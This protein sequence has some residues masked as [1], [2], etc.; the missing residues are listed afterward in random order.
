MGSF[1]AWLKELIH[2]FK[3]WLWPQPV[4]TP[5]PQP[6]PE[7]EP[8]ATTAPPP[9]PQVAPVFPHR[10]GKWVKPK[11]QRPPKSP[12]AEGVLRQPRTPSKPKPAPTSLADDPEQYGQYYFRDAIL[13]QLDVY[14]IYLKRMKRN[15][16]DAYNMHRKL[17]IHIMPQSAIRNFDKWRRDNEEAELSAWWKVNRP[18]F[19]AV[20]YG[21][22]ADSLEEEQYQIV[23]VSP[24]MM[25]RIRKT[26]K[27]KWDDGKHY[28]KMV[29][30]TGGKEFTLPDGKTH[31]PAIIWV[32]KFLYFTKWSKVP[33]D[34]Q[35]VVNGDVYSMT[36]YWDRTTGMSNTY[37][38]RHK[39]GAP[40]NYAICVDRDTG[41][42]R[43][44]KTFICESI[45]I[46]SKKMAGGSFKIPHKHW[47]YPTEYVSGASGRLDM[48]PEEYLCRVFMEAAL[49]YE[50]ASLGSMVRIT[51]SKDSGKLNAVF[52]VDIK[53]MA[54]FFKD[55]DVVLN[56]KGSTARIFHIVRPH[57]RK[58]GASVPMHFRGLKSFNWANYKID[59]TVPGR[60]HLHLSSWD[61]GSVNLT[62]D[63]F[64]K[65]KKKKMLDGG[66]VADRLKQYMKDGLG[67]WQK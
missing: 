5:D 48:P 31:K 57:T 3:L 54:Y 33:A 38:K 29:T 58:S 67:A 56:A 1:T 60:D 41:K 32:P 52:G 4:T 40:Q 43:L 12:A 10:P 23:D 15:D 49:M 64:K 45:T 11:G 18:G 27:A 16:I 59:I 66:Q 21:I 2:K 53:R 19:G 14:F 61:V 37:H 30:I 44:L 9:A 47:G 55:R 34:V 42:V 22:D 62:P 39:G 35:K 46:A 17:G 13:D 6:M 50:N 51:A 28:G 36:I 63:E 7:P 20:S 65:E 26:N 25:E 8:V 24:E